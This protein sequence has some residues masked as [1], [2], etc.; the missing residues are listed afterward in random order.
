MR[1]RLYPRSEA[2]I[3]RAVGGTNIMAVTI[4]TN[5]FNTLRVFGKFDHNQGAA[6]VTTRLRLNNIT[7]ASYHGIRST[8]VAGG[9]TGL[10]DQHINAQVGIDFDAGQAGSA[11]DM[12]IPA[13]SKS[14]SLKGMRLDA[15]ARIGSGAASNKVQT[16]GAYNADLTGPVTEI[17]A[18]PVGAG[19]WAA[20]A[21]LSVYGI[22]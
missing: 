15:Y 13:Y 5:D 1:G 22:M 12:I 18:F 8:V 17:R 6:F 16:I 19:V 9:G 21:E 11:F 3:G 14:G 2:L 4:P 7:A 10:I 20:T